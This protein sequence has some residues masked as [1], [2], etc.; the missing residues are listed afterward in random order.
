MTVQVVNYN[1][2]RDQRNLYSMFTEDQLQSDN[3]K[4]LLELKKAYDFT[5]NQLR[6]EFRILRKNIKTTN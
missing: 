5:E 1:R 6:K 3:C 4:L 2:I